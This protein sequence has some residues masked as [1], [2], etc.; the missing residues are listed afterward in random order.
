MVLTRRLWGETKGSPYHADSKQFKRVDTYGTPENCSVDLFLIILENVILEMWL[1][2][3]L[4][5]YINN[6][7]NCI[8]LMRDKIFDTHIGDMKRNNAV[9]LPVVP[10]KNKKNKGLVYIFIPK[11]MQKPILWNLQCSRLSHI[12]GKGV[13]DNKLRLCPPNG[14][15]SNHWKQPSSFFFPRSSLHI[16]ITI[17]ELI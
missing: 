10:K 11:R 3:A 17:D 16:I 8:Q 14:F 2:E 13:T 6:R 7:K 1:T 4:D 9:T 12:K 15:K 5:K